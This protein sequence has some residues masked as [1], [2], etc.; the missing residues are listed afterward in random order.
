MALRPTISPS[1]I[2][3]E[4]FTILSFCENKSGTADSSF[5]PYAVKRDW[6]GEVFTINDEVTNGT[7]MTGNITGFHFLENKVYVDHTWSGVGMNLGSL[8]KIISL[9]SAF[10]VD[11]VVRL[12]F[13]KNGDPIT[14]TVRGVH[15]YK[16]KVKYDL[17]LWLGDGS[18]DDPETET[19]VYNVDSCFVFLS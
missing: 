14:A 1:V 10:Q 17:G 19:R 18:V 8:S 16:G 6:D 9:P 3:F 4:K 7:K 15:F 5:K 2:D 11:Q 13:Q 12:R